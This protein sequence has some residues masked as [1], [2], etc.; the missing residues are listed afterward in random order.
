M[1]FNKHLTLAGTHALFGAS[2]YHW[3]NYT[4]D[5]VEHAV[6]TAHAAR[7][8]TQMHALA[9]DLIRM[10]VKLPDTPA[11]INQY[12]N[13][14]IGFRMTP[15]Q[16]LCYSPNF[17]GTADAICFRR[18]FLRIHDFKNGVVKTSV[19]QL[20]VYAAFFCLEYRVKP[21]QINT[22][23]R[24]YQNNEVRA[25]DADPH[26][27]VRIMDNIMTFDKIVEAVKLETAS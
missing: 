12:V 16:V 2:S 13:D 17:F 7:R 26:E 6:K 4:P 19:N 11:T 5:K 20:Y 25:Y 22:E 9:H 18:D 27:V 10:G 23:L 3:I 15:E 21:H 1:D 24:I 14:A 8:G